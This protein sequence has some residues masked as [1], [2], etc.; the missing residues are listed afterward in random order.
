MVNLGL[1]ETTELFALSEAAKACTF[2]QQH[3]EELR[4][5][6]RYRSGEGSLASCDVDLVHFQ[7]AAEGG[8]RSI[9]STRNSLS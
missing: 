4:T 1:R 3:G 9:G 2:L 7:V 5:S 8:R 6:L